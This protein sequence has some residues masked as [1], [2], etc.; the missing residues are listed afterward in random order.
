MN[1][2]TAGIGEAVSYIE[3]NLDG[4]INI[5]KAAEKAFVST[6]YF[7][8]IFCV[9]C[10]FT[11]GEYI[12]YRRLS[13]AGEELSQGNAKVIDV[14]L[15]YGYDSPD[16]FARA[17]T[18]FHGITP[19]AAKEHGTVLRS[20][21]PIKLKLTLE[22][23]TMI[24][25]RITEKP[26][27]TVV[28]V[29]TPIENDTSI[30]YNVIPTLWDEHYKNGGG[31]KIRGDFG[32]CIYCDEKTFTYMIADAYLPWKDIP[33]GCETYTFPA[34]TWAVFPC[35]GALPN[36][37][38]SLNTKIWSEWLPNLKGY[39]LSGYYNLEMYTPSADKP[40]DT[41]SEIWIPIEKA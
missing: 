9:L 27:F 21:A 13:L 11:I 3:H 30:S 10:G 35:K 4:E 24:D 38:Q 39:K 26:A 40:E 6:F 18:K 31:E 28:G 19:S 7:Q 2:W 22:G 15:K 23:G 41:Y 34:G 8:K 14:A 5:E 20:F 29:T 12:R 1:D 32:A 33:D 37:L 17:F 16:S 25:Y 36:A